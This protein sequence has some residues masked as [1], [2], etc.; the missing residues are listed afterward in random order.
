LKSY[1]SAFVMIHFLLERKTAV[2]VM[3]AE[4]TW[5]LSLSVSKVDQNKSMI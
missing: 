4:N 3:G 5:V 1:V 2:V